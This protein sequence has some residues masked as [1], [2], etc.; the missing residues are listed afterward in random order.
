MRNGMVCNMIYPWQATLW[1]RLDQSLKQG[2]LAHALLLSGEKGNGKLT[3][4]KALAQKAL[5]QQPAEFACGQCKSCLLIAADTH[6]DYLLIEPDGKNIKIDQ[7]RQMI[8][9]LNQ[10]AQQSAMKVVIIAPAEAMNTAAA[11]ALLKCL[12][13]PTAKTL[14]ILLSHAPQ[15]LLPTIR[16]R[17]QQLV[18]SKPTTEQAEQYLQ[19]IIT[20]AAQR[21]QLLALAN[22]NPLLAEQFAQMDL[23]PLQEQLQ[24]LLIKLSQGQVNLVKEA[25]DLLQKAGKT[26][27]EKSASLEQW[28]RINQLVLSQLIRAGL[29]QTP[30]PNWASA[31]Q[32]LL[33]QPLFIRHL[34]QLLDDLQENIRQLQG[35][36]NPNLQLLTESILI[37][38]QA[39]FKKP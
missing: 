35:Q 29:A 4:A 16:S 23:L 27:Q 6:P 32:T 37:R 3:L 31:L 2:R 38:W 7:I 14:I 28:L 24:Q 13:E 33:Q 18:L 39:A 36:S 10:T 5:C 34:F 12:E 19:P 1:Q 25:D 17:C 30:L 20:D 21:Q 15:R 22:G 9:Q 26:Q 8:E 11:N